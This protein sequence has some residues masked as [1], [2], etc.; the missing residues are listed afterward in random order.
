MKKKNKVKL[1]SSLHRIEPREISFEYSRFFFWKSI[2]ISKKKEQPAQ[3]S[4]KEIFNTCVGKYS[5]NCFGTF[6]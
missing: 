6:S 1:R 3:D 2:E 4:N 5:P